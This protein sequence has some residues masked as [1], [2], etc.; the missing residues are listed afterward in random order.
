MAPS[1]NLIFTGYSG[2]PGNGIEER[3][4]SHH[5]VALTLRRHLLHR[6]PDDRV[7]I[8][9]AWHKNTFLR[10]L[11]TPAFP[12]LPLRQIHYVGH[13]H[14]GGLS[15]G[16]GNTRARAER[17]R[18][19]SFLTT[20]PISALPAGILRQ[21][22]LWNESALLTGLMDVL[23]PAQRGAIAGRFAPGSMMHIWGC[24]AG[25]GAHL[26]DTNDEY[27]R[28]A[29]PPGGR[30]PGIA[31]HLAQA[32]GIPVTAS[33]HPA[34]VH[35]MNFWYRDA[36]GRLH[37]DRRPQRTPQWLWPAGTARWITYDAHGT[38]HERRIIFL[39]TP[40]PATRLAPGSPPPWLR[41]EIPAMAATNLP[42]APACSPTAVPVP[43]AP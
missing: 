3:D 38:G 35:G 27:W 33:F 11:L 26:F 25:A 9:C 42:A 43:A 1:L 32:L 13:G 31:R 10:T 40:T 5:M 21:I 14:G 12:R 30:A 6:F 15:F 16:F 23:T 34:G 20:R 28:L 29:N 37:T 8:V 36:I 17:D 7:E 22:L 18:S 19:A 4:R 39:G 2:A 24:F 41:A